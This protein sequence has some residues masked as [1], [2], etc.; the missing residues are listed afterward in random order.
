M[1]RSGLTFLF[2]FVYSFW[3]REIAYLY[4]LYQICI[5]KMDAALACSF[6][7]HCTY[8]NYCISFILDEVWI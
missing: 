4:E 7:L 6:F 5:V 1:Y 2:S 3:N 8:N